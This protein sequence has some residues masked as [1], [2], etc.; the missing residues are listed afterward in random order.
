LQLVDLQEL[1]DETLELAIDRINFNQVIFRNHLPKIFLAYLL[2]KAKMKIALINIIINA[3]E[4]MT[5][6]KRELTLSTQQQENTI[7]LRIRDTGKGMS[8]DQLEKLFEP[9]FTAKPNGLGLGLTSTKNILNSHSATILVESE[10][11]KG[12]TFTLQFTLAS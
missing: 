5:G 9:F 11:N 1:V 6:D 2:D 4:A 3:I 7:L 12:T 10:L 8:A